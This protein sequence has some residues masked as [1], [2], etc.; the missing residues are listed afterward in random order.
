MGF[1]PSEGFP[2]QVVT[3]PESCKGFVRK[4]SGLIENGFQPFDDEVF[5]GSAALSSR[6]FSP[7][8]DLIGQID[9]GLH[10]AIFMY[11][12]GGVKVRSLVPELIWLEAWSRW[13]GSMIC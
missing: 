3:L 7:L 5:Y 11:L 10:A 6:D 9:G 1:F 13:A 12:W 8:K 4:G 2:T